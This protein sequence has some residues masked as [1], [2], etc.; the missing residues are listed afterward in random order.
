MNEKG[1]KKGEYAWYVIGVTPVAFVTVWWVTMTQL[2]P[3]FQKPILAVIGAVIGALLLV[4]IGEWIHPSVAQ[5]PHSTVTEKR[6]AENMPTSS[7]E[8]LARALENLASQLEGAPPVVIGQ[9]TIAI[10]GPGGG[11]VIG[12]QVTATAGPGSTGTVIGK[13]VVA[14]SGGQATNAGRGEQLRQAAL[15]IRQGTATRNSIDAL[16]VSPPLPASVMTGPLAEAYTKARAALSASD[17]P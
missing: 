5:T 4:T 11:T 17:L 6:A 13:R 16:L 7:R 8:D 14:S 12:E 1:N 3:S 15:G 2:S 9:Q 10:G